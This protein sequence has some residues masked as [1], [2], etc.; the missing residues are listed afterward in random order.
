MP[1]PF[2][3]FTRWTLAVFAV[4][5]LLLLPVLGPGYSKKGDL[6]PKEQPPK[7]SKSQCCSL[8]ARYSD[9]LALTEVCVTNRTVFRLRLLRRADTCTIF[10]EI[11]LRDQTGRRYQPLSNDGPPECGARGYQTQT[12]PRIY[13]WSFEK[14]SANARTID[15]LENPDLGPPGSSYT[16]FMGVS[17]APCKF[18]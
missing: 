11:I 18:R 10:K 13:T 16:N 5:L 8:S 4:G 15:L 12:P 14:L 3:K 1:F 6:K 7:E 2:M 9:L 17:L